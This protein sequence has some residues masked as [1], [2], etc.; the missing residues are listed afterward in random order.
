MEELD[1]LKKKRDEISAKINKIIG[2]KEKRLTKEA[3][4][5][6]GKCYKFY[7]SM[8]G[9]EKFM[10]YLK[11]TK[12]LSVWIQGETMTVNVEGVEV[13]DHKD[14]YSINKETTHLSMWLDNPISNKQF[15][16]VYKKVLGKLS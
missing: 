6:V 15:D 12:I 14:I 16:K 4:K 8:S 3:Q 13:N 9:G 1:E 5:F 10:T 7:N 2:E 11:V